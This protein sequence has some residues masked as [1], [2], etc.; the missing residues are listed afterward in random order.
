MRENRSDACLLSSR[1]LPRAR[2]GRVCSSSRRSVPP[3]GRFSA[4]I[5]W[6]EHPHSVGPLADPRPWGLRRVSESGGTSGSSGSEP[7]RRPSS[8]TWCRFSARSSRGSCSER[9]SWRLGTRPF[10]RCQDETLL[11]M[12]NEVRIATVLSAGLPRDR[13][14]GNLSRPSVVGHPIAALPCGIHPAVSGLLRVGAARRGPAAVS[15]SADPP[16][17]CNRAA[18]SPGKTAMDVLSAPAAGARLPAWDRTE[19]HSATPPR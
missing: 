5:P 12:R 9:R 16:R 18:N 11:S 14:Q 15:A 13:S 1:N 7:G 4:R 10:A 19:S 3:M 2:F 8:A 6:L 17:P